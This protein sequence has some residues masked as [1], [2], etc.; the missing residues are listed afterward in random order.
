M[1]RVRTYERLVTETHVAVFEL[2][3]YNAQV[4]DSVAAFLN[5]DLLEDKVG[6]L[7]DL[8]LLPARGG[9]F[10]VFDRLTLLEL[11]GV[12]LLASFVF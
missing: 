2:H 11:V 9:S 6:V 1:W 7:D 3:S 4:E 5:E 12:R 10:R 8:G